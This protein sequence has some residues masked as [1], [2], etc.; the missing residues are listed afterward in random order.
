MQV[1][2]RR[3]DTSQPVLLTIQAGRVVRAEYPPL[4]AGERSV[5]PWVSP[6]WF[7][8]Q[9][10]G[11][12]GREFSSGDLTADDVKRIAQAMGRLGATRFLAT[13][14]TE[15][16]TVLGHALATITAAC[17]TDAAT[18]RRIAGVHLEGPFISPED[19]P[20]GA[21]PRAHCRLP[22]IGEFE[23]LQAVARGRIRLL[24]LAPE[25]PGA[26]RLIEAA[27]EAG[28]AVAI[29][30]TAAH[31][32]EIHAAVEAGARLSTHLGNGAHPMLPRHP[33]YIW[34]QL[35]D[36]RLWAS[37]IADGH[38]VPGEV[39]R[40]FV[41]AKSPSRCVLISDLSGQAGQPPGRYPGGLCEVEILESGKL[42]IAGQSELLAGATAPL[43][44]GIA[45]VM[46]D[47]QVPLAEAVDMASIRPARL[48]GMKHGGFVPGDWAD[49]TLF[50]IEASDEG[51]PPAIEVLGA[52][53]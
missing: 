47:V 20:R 4:T 1:L 50:R 45:R 51:R 49:F 41:R 52:A 23:R 19:G 5:L 35:S 26:L 48:L 42:V 31:A 27:T 10:N 46:Y 30:H 3:Y 16:E 33:N 34:H 22:N 44:T 15:N 13:V 40:C 7:D 6:G 28:V 21:H 17:E 32:A 24:T 14:T 25:L 2:A 43:A 29:G 18:G 36:D 53:A 9:V 39:L 8:L 38:H 37:L 12:G 11:Y